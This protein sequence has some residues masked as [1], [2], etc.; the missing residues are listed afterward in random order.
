MAI[1]NIASCTTLNNGVQM[2]LLGLGVYRIPAG[3]ATYQAVRAALDVGYRHIDTAS[4]YGNEAD[5]GRAIRDAGG[6]GKIFVTT[7]VWNDQQGYQQCRQAIQQSLNNLQLD[8]IDLFLIHWPIKRLFKGTYQAMTEAFHRGWIKALGFSNFASH[9][10]DEAGSCEVAATVNQVECH[11]RLQQQQLLD[12]CR[13]NKIALE[14]WRPL[15]AG[16]VNQIPLLVQLAEKYRKSAFQ[17]TIRWLL[18]RGIAVI[19]KSSHCERIASNAAVFDFQLSA[20]EMAAIAK[21]DQ[22]LRLGKDPDDFCY[23]N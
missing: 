13:H 9:H 6:S 21:L 2:P 22:G 15:M 3:E 16:K 4:F 19:P 8:A 1:L 11:P 14:S 23:N 18:Q 20:D 5:V 7:K 17:V 12:F 10:I